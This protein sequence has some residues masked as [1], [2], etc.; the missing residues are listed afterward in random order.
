MSGSNQSLNTDFLE[1]R[2]KHLMDFLRVEVENEQRISLANEGFGLRDNYNLVKG[3]IREKS[4][5]SSVG[6]S[7]TAAGLLN[8]EAAK[9]IFCSGL[10]L[11]E[12]C[13]K[14]QK[15]SFDEKK[16]ILSEKKACFRCLKIGH[17]IRKCRSKLKCVI[18]GQSHVPL[19]C[20]DLATIKQQSNSLDT[21]KVDNANK[22]QIFANQ[23]SAHVFLQT[24]RVAIKGKSGVRMVRALVDT[25]SQRSYILKST[26]NSLGLQPKRA[27][28]IIH[29]LFGGTETVNSHYCY[30]V[31]VT[32][33]NYAHTFEV[34]DQFYICNEVSPIFY[35][36]WMDELERL[37]IDVSDINNS[38][39]IELL[40][41]AD[42]AEMLYTGRSHILECGLV[43][44][45]TRIGW[46]VMGKV[47]GSQSKKSATMTVLSLFVNPSITELWQLDVLGIQDPTDKKSK[48]EMA[49]AAKELFLQ[50][51]SVNPKGRYEVNLPWIDGHPALPTNYTLAKKR[52][53]STTQK[54]E[55]SDLFNRYDE[56]FKEW[57]QLNIIQIV[58][59]HDIS[60]HFLPHRPVLKEGSTTA[61]RPV[62]DASAREK[63]KPSL[64]QCIEK[65]LNLIELIPALLTRFRENKIG[66]ISDIKKAFLQISIHENDRNYLKFLW[67][68]KNGQEIIFR[69]RRVVFGVNCSP[70]LL[71]ATIEYHLSNCLKNCSLPNAVYS[72]ETIEKL[73]NSFYVDNCV[74][75]LPSYEDLH[76]FINEA[77]Q[78]MAEGKFDLRGWE[79]TG[80]PDCEDFKVP[81]LGLTWYSKQDF[82]TMNQDILES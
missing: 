48:D 6:L 71:E 25:G 78:V 5:K 18:C 50:T 4:L 53:D 44:I 73:S 63:D 55:K 77:V 62:F 3:K 29:C 66:V 47:P 2:M 49:L 36:P 24:L 58:P 32:S 75:S 46:T 70:F 20:L 17:Q 19:M 57:R 51:V 40:L 81:V 9:C 16:N 31:T 42:V 22:D 28:K 45:E 54:L 82:L 12:A 64:N 8:A 76:K 14:A 15:M 59:D 34:L 35:G 30:D 74:T 79:Y 43:A 23:T 26:V 13:F 33:G 65:G 69:H 27:E 7:P 68:D 21:H 52:L 56:V 11:S 10:H 61:V 60:G 67:I 37:K 41:G 72:Q 80:N 39:S 38:G 1:V